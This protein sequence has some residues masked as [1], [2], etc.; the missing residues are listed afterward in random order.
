MKAPMIVTSIAMLIAIV[1]VVPLEAQSA[2]PA[3]PTFDVASVKPNKSAGGPFAIGFQP[4][5]RFIAT[6][7]TLRD[8]IAVAYGKPQPLPN[9]QI[10]GAPDWIAS[11]RFDIEAK[12]DTLS[13]PETNRQMLQALLADRFKVLA[14]TET[15]ELPIYVL[16]LARSDGRLGPQLRRAAVDCAAR[17]ATAGTTAAPLA[18]PPPGQAASC[19]IGGGP[20]RIDGGDATMAQIV[21]TPAG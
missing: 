13:S 19:G 18:P 5:G 6:N 21:N 8:L 14:H 12:T 2:P 3:N 7:A 17:R 4:G 16:V 9:F 20:G 10:F 1:A 15:R 11:E